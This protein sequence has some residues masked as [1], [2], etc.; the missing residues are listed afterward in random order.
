MAERQR[1]VELRA[2][3]FVL[4]TIL[5]LGLGSLWVIGSL[6]IGREANQYSVLMGTAAGVRPGDRVR[7]SGIEVGRVESVSLRPGEEWP[8]LFRITLDASISVTEEASAHITSDGLLSFNYL[9]IDPGPAS[10]G[11]LLPG[12]A[13]QGTAGAGLMKALGGLEDLSG[14]TSGFLAKLGGLVDELSASVEPLLARLELLLSDENVDSF[15]DTLTAMRVLAEDTRPRTNVLLEHLDALV[16]QLDEG[17]EDLPQIAENLDSFLAELRNALGTDGAR[18][19]EL[20]ESAQGTLD[21]AGA[22]L[23]VTAQNR[24]RLEL[25]LRDLQATIASLK[26]FTGALEERPSA[27]VWKDRQPDRKPGEGTQ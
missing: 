15:S 9:E 26:S 6:P 13:I 4:A 17:T 3:V 20:L 27:L 23:E 8:V 22:T 2:G 5:I 14:Q 19:A 18:L 1:A 25:A 7:V 10:A 12:S 16:A 24:R 11:A 21:S